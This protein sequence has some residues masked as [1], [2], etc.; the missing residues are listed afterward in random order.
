M[1]TYITYV[2]IYNIYV[3]T[4]ISQDVQYFVNNGDISKHLQTRFIDENFLGQL[5]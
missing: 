2:N 4:Y 5:I 1:L 3:L